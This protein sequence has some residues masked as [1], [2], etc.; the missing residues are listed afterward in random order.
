MIKN[1]IN[2]RIGIPNFAIVNIENN[3]ATEKQIKKFGEILNKLNNKQEVIACP[4]LKIN[5]KFI[6]NEFKKYI[7]DTSPTKLQKII[8]YL[9]HKLSIWWFE[10]TGGLKK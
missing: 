3:K 2:R 10:L 7:C 6:D 8:R 4:E 5:V 9:P 1:L